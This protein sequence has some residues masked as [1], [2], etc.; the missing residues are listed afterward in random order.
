ML[1]ITTHDSTRNDDVRRE[2]KLHNLS[3]EVLTFERDFE[4]GRRGCFTSHQRALAEGVQQGHKSI[5]I[6]EN[7]VHFW[8]RAHAAQMHELVNEARALVET[9]PAVIVGLGGLAI[10]P[11]RSMMPAPFEKFA[12]CR[13]ACA[14]AYVV[15]KEAAETITSWSYDGEHYDLELHRH[16][17]TS[18]ALLCPTVAF[19]KPYFYQMTTTENTILY[20]FLTASRNIMTPVF[21]QLVFERWWLILGAVCNLLRFK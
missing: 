13:F 17:R 7:D 19:Q 20:L 14:H 18:M 6:F 15:S 3:V 16:F 12:R 8:T 2:F 1:C 11:I 9:N 4:D 5:V 21:V 10:S